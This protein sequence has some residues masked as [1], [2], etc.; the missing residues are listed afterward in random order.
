M[1]TTKAVRLEGQPGCQSPWFYFWTLLFFI[2][3]PAFDFYW[4]L[5]SVGFSWFLLL[6]LLLL[7][8]A[9]VVVVGFE[10]EIL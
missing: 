6:L 10:D 2:F 3:L 4:L 1:A 9:V 8:V 5:A 7:L